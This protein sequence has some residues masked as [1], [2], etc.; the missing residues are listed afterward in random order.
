MRNVFVILIISCLSVGASGASSVRLPQN[1][2]DEIR[3][4][5]Q[6]DTF[7]VE[8]DAWL[9]YVEHQ[10]H[11]KY[12]E[13]V[14]MKLAMG[15]AKDASKE[16]RKGIAFMRME[17]GRSVKEGQAEVRRSIAIL[18]MIDDKIKAGTII[19]GMHLD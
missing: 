8:G 13:D 1:P 19:D 4:T 6:A 3:H 9:N 14:Q 12:F 18:Q 11:Q 2:Q 15:D 5:P 10:V 7:P 17:S 16:L